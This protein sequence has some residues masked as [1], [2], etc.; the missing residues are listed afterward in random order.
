MNACWSPVCFQ[1]GQERSRP[2]HTNV[3]T[4]L[5]IAGT[6]RREDSLNVG[7]S[8][9]QEFCVPALPAHLSTGN[10]IVCWLLYTE[11][12][13]I[14]ETWDCMRFSFRICKCGPPSSFSSLHLSAPMS[15]E[16]AH[17]FARICVNVLRLYVQLCQARNHAYTLW[18]TQSVCLRDDSHEPLVSDS[19][20]RAG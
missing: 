15:P 16:C 19:W 4:C 1:S 17:W 5:H 18:H 6:N 2:G 11:L 7:I 8:W 10:D 20:V 3:P 9:W 12:M 13:G 14:P